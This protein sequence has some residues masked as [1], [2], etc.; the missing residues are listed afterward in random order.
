MRGDVLLQGTIDQ[1]E[2]CS[3]ILRGGG[4][5]FIDRAA[6]SNATY[7]NDTDTSKLRT[8][9]WPMTPQLK[10][11]RFDFGKVYFYTLVHYYF[12]TRLKIHP[13]NMSSLDDI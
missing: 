7:K 9:G 2:G 10:L 13:V 6:L 5:L 12:S 4:P 3:R 1:R 11:P 8:R